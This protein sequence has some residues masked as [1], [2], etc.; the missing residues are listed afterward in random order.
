MKSKFPAFA[1]NSYQQ[2]VPKFRFLTGLNLN[3]EFNFL[4]QKPNLK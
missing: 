3:Q 1:T 2:E 4:V